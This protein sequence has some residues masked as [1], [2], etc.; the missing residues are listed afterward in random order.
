M[1]VL[2]GIEPIS[3]FEYFEK[4]CS[5]PHGSGNT[6]IISD[7]LVGFAHELG[8]MCRQDELNNV[9]IFKKA[10]AGYENAEPVILQGHMDMVCAKTPE[11]EKNMAVEGL[12]LAVDGD[13]LHAVNTSLGGDDCIAV[14]MALAILADD[15]L[16]HPALEVVFTVDEEVGM[17]GAF[18]LDMSDLKG[19]RLLNIDSEEEGVFTVSCAGGV[20]ADCFIPSKSVKLNE[21]NGELFGKLG[22]TILNYDNCYKLSL[23]GLLGGHSGCEI[24]KG[25]GNA[26]KLMARFLYAACKK[27]PGL[28]LNSLSGGRFD[29]VIC[30]ESEAV[31][32]VPFGQE[33]CFEKMVSE[34]NQIY[35]NEYAAA[36]PNVELKI[37]SKYKIDNNTL[38]FKPEDSVKIISTLFILPQGV[39]EMSMDLKGLVQTSLN[40]GVISTDSKG[41]HFS[42]SIRSSIASQKIAVLDR[43]IAIVET[44]GG[45]VTTRGMYP[46]WAY[47]RNSE[48]RSLLERIY[49]E[50]TGKKAV[51]SA[52]HGGL[53][54][55][56]FIEK[57]PG[58]DCVSIGPELRDI[59]S[60]L[61]KLSI[62]SVE[63]LY[64]LVVKVLEEMTK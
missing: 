63:R 17:D 9:V 27:L 13:W 28:I 29:N 40:M 11:C 64:K 7:M 39:I 4:L 19:R 23:D 41:V 62:T 56:L 58:L 22:N 49:E 33:E 5:V 2:N 43:V 12:D 54:C 42:F 10:S 52:T 21:C 30:P 14:A 60:P 32:S 15:T 44:A 31:V 6:K 51:I 61:E 18:G 50:Q 35:K 36:D 3:V 24:D 45:S 38:F 46:G 47:N 34:Y 53:E 8:L 59:H 55:G 57:L 20:R 48:F 16:K 37:D 26:I 1:S 25:R